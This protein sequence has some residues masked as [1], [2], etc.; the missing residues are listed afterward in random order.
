MGLFDKLGFNSQKKNEFTQ[1]LNK[2]GYSVGSTTETGKLDFGINRYTPKINPYNNAE[3]VKF[4]VADD[5]PLVL[6][7]FFYSNSLHANIIRDRVKMMSGLK[8]NVV[9]EPTGYYEKLVFHKILNKADDKNSLHEVMKKLA[10]DYILY[11]A[12]SAEVL[13]TED[14]SMVRSIKRLYNGGVRVLKYNTLY[15]EAMQY[16]YSPDLKL[17]KDMQ[18]Y[19]PYNPFD[20]C[21][22]QLAYMKRDAI[23]QQV[24][25]EPSYISGLT[26]IA[27][28]A[29][30]DDHLTGVLEDGFLNPFMMT[31]LN[32]GFTTT[33]DKQR[34]VEEWTQKYTEARE[35]ARPHVSFVDDYEQKPQMDEIPQNK[36]PKEFIS[37]TEQNNE[38]IVFAH[39]IPQ[40]LLL[41]QP[42]QLGNTKEIENAYKLWD[43]KTVADDRMMLQNFI[44][45][46]LKISGLGEIE[47]VPYTVFGLTKEEQQ[48]EKMKNLPQQILDTLSIDEKRELGGYE[49]LPVVEGAPASNEKSLAEIIG[50]GGVTALSAVVG[51]P[52][53]DKASKAQFLQVVFGLSEEKANRLVYGTPIAPSIDSNPVNPGETQL[54]KFNREFGC[55]MGFFNMSLMDVLSNQDSAI[56]IDPNDIYD[57]GS[58]NYGLITDEHHCTILYG[59]IDSEIEDDEMECLL[60]GLVMPIVKGISISTFENDEY[61]VLKWDI[62]S[63]EFSM[64][65]KMLTSMYPY[66]N[67]YPEYSAHSTIAYL[68]KGTAEKYITTFEEI[69]EVKVSK[70]VYSK[71]DGSKIIIDNEGNSE[72]K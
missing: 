8:L 66:E 21:E 5:Y 7:D 56:T 64:Y 72:Y 54:N 23:K 31:F 67:K 43:S 12:F 6:E 47:I 22:R 3:W 19:V 34:F 17:R 40:A 49:P 57:D 52:N 58:G 4:G 1:P 14:L 20:K 32:D 39:D 51:D 26:N 68:K 9:A 60:K 25:G 16:V 42:G 71:S 36:N 48:I 33:E 59:L 24:Y 50:V 62:N 46:L 38:K 69:P 53:L 30:I 63:P 10:F 27:N 41:K 29:L 35:K 37:L 65:N 15:E 28:D 45:E 11:G 55:V 13:W 2:Q 18:Y 44:N 61:D 70:W